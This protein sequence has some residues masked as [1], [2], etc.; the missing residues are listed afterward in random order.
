MSV[1]TAGRSLTGSAAAVEIGFRFTRHFPGN[2][3][4]GVV[5]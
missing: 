5:G 3:R 2:I 4:G 1:P